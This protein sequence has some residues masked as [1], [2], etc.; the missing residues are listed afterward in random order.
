MSVADEATPRINVFLL[1]LP[2]VSSISSLA[3]IQANVLLQ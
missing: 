2:Q 1:P 3:R